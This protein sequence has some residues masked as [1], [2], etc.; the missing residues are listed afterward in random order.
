MPD[1]RENEIYDNGAHRTRRYYYH[2]AAKSHAQ[3]NFD[4]ELAGNAEKLVVR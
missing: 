4:C 3:F 2:A 1:S